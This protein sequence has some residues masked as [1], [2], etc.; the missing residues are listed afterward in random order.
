MDRIDELLNTLIQAQDNYHVCRGVFD[1][2]M[3]TGDERRAIY[4]KLEAD[5]DAARQQIADEY[6]DL[7]AALE[8]AGAA[9]AEIGKLATVNEGD[10][11]TMLPYHAR[12]LAGLLNEA[13]PVVGNAL[14]RARGES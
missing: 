4:D 10:V 11:I 12:K 14:A 6:R 7:L 2:D 3:L 8:G 5:R 1:D 13:V 9:L